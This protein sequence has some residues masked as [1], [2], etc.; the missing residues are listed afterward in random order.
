MNPLKNKLDKELEEEGKVLIANLNNKGGKNTKAK[1]LARKGRDLD[2]EEFRNELAEDE[3]LVEAQE[4]GGKLDKIVIARKED[5]RKDFRKT[6]LPKRK[7]QI[8]KGNGGQ[9]NKG[10]FNNKKVKKN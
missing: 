3:T 7:D 5:S 9:Q 8:K 2:E 1:P 4:V 6:D 10:N